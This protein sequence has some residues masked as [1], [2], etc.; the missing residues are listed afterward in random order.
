[1]KPVRVQRKRTRGFKLPENT[2]SVTRCSYFGNP[3][4]VEKYGRERAVQLFKEA[5]KVYKI[6]QLPEDCQTDFENSLFWEHYMQSNH[7]SITEMVQ[8]ELKDKNLAC[9][10]KEGELCHADILLEIANN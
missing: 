6:Q 10:C 2:K 3:F 5:F 1:M 9:Y 8:E 4:T 7:C